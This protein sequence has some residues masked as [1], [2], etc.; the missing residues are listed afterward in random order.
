MR[1]GQ[2]FS[3]S[4]RVSTHRMRFG[5]SP[6]LSPSRLLDRESART[7]TSLQVSETVHWQ[8]RRASDKLQQARF[9]LNRPGL[10][11]LFAQREGKKPQ[12]D[13]LVLCGDSRR[14]LAAKEKA[15]APPRTIARP[16]P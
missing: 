5:Q 7:V 10:D 8:A 15:S 12:G 14:E 3:L 13:E 16:D 11:S 9:S 6:A 4:K 2:V 1:S